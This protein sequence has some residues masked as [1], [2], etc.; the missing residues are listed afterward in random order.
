MLPLQGALVPVLVIGVRHERQTPSPSPGGGGSAR[1]AR[2][3]G[4]TVHD[5]RTLMFECNHI[6]IKRVVERAVYCL[7]HALDVSH[8]LIVPEA[9]NAVALLLKPLRTLRVLLHSRLASML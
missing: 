1:V 8:H 7:Q 3:G 2:R 4:V 9:Q 6:R 5:A